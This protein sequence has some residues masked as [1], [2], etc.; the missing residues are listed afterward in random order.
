MYVMSPRSYSACASPIVLFTPNPRD[1]LAACCNEDVVKGAGGLELAG[2][3]SR[4]T[5]LMSADLRA[6]TARSDSRSLFGRYFL[7]FHRDTSICTS[8][9][10]PV[11]S[12]ESSQYS[13]GTNARICLSRST[14]S[15]TATDWTRPADSPRDTFFQRIGETMNPTIRSRNRRACCALTRL[16]SSSLGSSKALRMAFSVISLNTTRWY[17]VGSPPRISRRCQA[18]ASPSRSISVANTMCSASMAKEISSSATL[19][20]PSMISHRASQPP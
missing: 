20:L 17:R 2:L 9:P 5:T 16:M 4:L 1:V 18:I 15:F 12:A 8:F 3:S 6:A 7:P 19:S 13:S 11:R 14:T 10:S